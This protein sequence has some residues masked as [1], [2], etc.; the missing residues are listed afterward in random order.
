MEEGEDGRDSASEHKARGENEVQSKDAE[1]RGCEAALLGKRTHTV[2]VVVWEDL[3]KVG[4]W[5]PGL[6]DPESGVADL[7]ALEDVEACPIGPDVR[8]RG[9]FR[10][11]SPLCGSVCR[12]WEPTSEGQGRGASG[13][14]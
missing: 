5:A 10:Y 12:T 4:P 13:D 7:Q 9:R 2:K 3:V 6:R 8:I 1:T 11:P 14:A